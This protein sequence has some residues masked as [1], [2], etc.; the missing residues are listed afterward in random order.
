MPLT[1]IDIEFTFNGTKG[2]A[3][4]WVIDEQCL[5]DLPLSAEHADIFLT[6]NKVED[7]SDLYPEHDGITVRLSKDDESLMELSTTE[8]FGSILLSEPQVVRLD[9][10]PYGRYVVSPNARFN[11]TEFEI[12][13]RDVTGLWPWAQGSDYSVGVAEV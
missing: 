6:A 11:G 12:T 7:I 8:Y 5:Y 13:D 1:D 2:V 4:V 3:L 9:K 10:Y